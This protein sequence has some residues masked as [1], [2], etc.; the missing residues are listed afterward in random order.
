MD[1]FFKTETSGRS[2]ASEVDT[3]QTSYEDNYGRSDY[4]YARYEHQLTGRPK[5][6]I[7]FSNCTKFIIALLGSANAMRR[8]NSSCL[9][10]SGDGY[11]VASTLKPKTVVPAATD[12]PPGQ[13]PSVF[14]KP[15]ADFYYV[16]VVPVK[17]FL[18]ILTDPSQF[19]LMME[20]KAVALLGEYKEF[21]KNRKM[22]T[23]VA[24]ERKFVLY[25]Y[26]F[27]GP[28]GSAENSQVEFQ[29]S[30]YGYNLSANKVEQP[31]PPLLR[32][33]KARDPC[34]VQVK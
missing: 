34:S 19:S 12:D 24:S 33:V 2:P 26:Q 14:G 3:V 9:D 21:N 15:E 30:L 31:D 18:N 7:I 10:F 17:Y 25:Q 16:A 11:I 1:L 29:L 27:R 4:I 5:K 22:E 6:P 32:D 28:R 20:S 13:P 23:R 8:R